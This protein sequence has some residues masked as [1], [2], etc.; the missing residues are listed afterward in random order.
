V[1]HIDPGAAA[2]HVDIAKLALASGNA[3][4]LEET[5]RILAKYFPAHLASLDAG[6]ASSA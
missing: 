3:A 2:I 1:E 5:R 6:P 4:L